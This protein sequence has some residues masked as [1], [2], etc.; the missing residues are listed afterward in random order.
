MLYNS[1]GFKKGLGVD[2]SE[3]MIQWFN[4]QVLLLFGIKIRQLRG[5]YHL[6]FVPIVSL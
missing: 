1:I 3:K 5:K 4:Q 6:Q 2:S